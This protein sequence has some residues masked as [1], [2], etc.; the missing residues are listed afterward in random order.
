M[1]EK[2][3]M[4]LAEERDNVEEN[5]EENTLLQEDK[6]TEFPIKTEPLIYKR[7]RLYNVVQVI[8]LTLNCTSA[9]VPI[10]PFSDNRLC[11]SVDKVDVSTNGS[12][13][14]LNKT[15]SN[16]IFILYIYIYIYVCMYVCMYNVH[17][18]RMQVML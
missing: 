16:N 5:R 10:K 3:L 6:I 18:E 9:T 4:R 13:D 2:D 17:V 1:T 7:K 11:I 8:V 15:C 14:D 12:V